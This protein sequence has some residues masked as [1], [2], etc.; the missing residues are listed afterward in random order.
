MGNRFV[1]PIP[2]PSYER[3][4]I[5]E[6]LIF[7]PNQIK[8]GSGC[9]SS[10]DVPNEIPCRYLKTKNRKSEYLLIVFHGNSEQIG[11]PTHNYLERMSRRLFINIICQ[12]YPKYGIYAKKDKSKDMPNA[13]MEDARTVIK[14]ATTE[15]GYDMNKIILFGRSIGSGIAVRMATEFDIRGLVLVSAYTS[16]RDIVKHKLSVLLSCCVSN[17]LRSKEHI[18]KVKCPILL[19]HGAKDDLIP[20]KMSEALTKM[21]KT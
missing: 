19:I 17:M 10:K 3:D 1:F 4:T 21:A 20:S 11:K 12:E 8:L 7:I 16:I 18:D 15:L 2:K 14:Y 9:C 13:I 6:T 5:P